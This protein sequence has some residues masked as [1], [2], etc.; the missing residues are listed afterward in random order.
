[1]SAV[2]EKD[3]PSMP[4]VFI[5]TIAEKEEELEKVKAKV[6]RQKKAIRELEELLKTYRTRIDVQL[7]ENRDYTRRIQE[8]E[9]QHVKDSEGISKLLAEER[10]LIIA[11]Y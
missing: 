8:L 11:E 9:D 5:D 10:R 1:M 3:L 2:N 6:V 4:R 7:T